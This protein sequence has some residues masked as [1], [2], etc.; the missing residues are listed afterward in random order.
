MPAR[1]H[2]RQARQAHE[3]F[4]LN[5]LKREFSRDP[6][7]RTPDQNFSAERNCLLTGFFRLA[8]PS[9]LPNLFQIIQSP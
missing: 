4:F 3:M 7:G 9:K 5:R 8:V 6:D 2:R 1:T